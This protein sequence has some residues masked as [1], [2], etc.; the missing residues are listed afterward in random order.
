MMP[1][2]ATSSAATPG[3]GVPPPRFRPL[4]HISHVSLAS[5]DYV[6]SQGL[7][8]AQKAGLR[9]EAHVQEALLGRFPAYQAGPV[10]RCLD[11]S[12]C[13]VLKPDGL[14]VVRQNL[15]LLPS[16]VFI[17]EIKH[18]HVPE[19]WWQLEKLY[20]RVLEKLFLCPISLVE[21]CRSYDPSMP[22][23]VPVTLI[24]D[25][26]DWITEPRSEFGVWTWRKI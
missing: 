22:F 19:A 17:F 24:S 7:T 23:P 5:T 12:V 9:Y 21:I 18:Q 6:R 13:R 20:K 14:F 16:H 2:L 4:G 15:R 10:V 26:E 3:V 8:E 1:A 11:D 25:L